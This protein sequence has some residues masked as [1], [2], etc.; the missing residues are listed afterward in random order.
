[1]CWILRS[2][3]REPFE[4]TQ[5]AAPPRPQSDVVGCT[6]RGAAGISGGGHS[7]A[8]QSVP[9]RSRDHG[10]VAQVE[11]ERGILLLLHPLLAH[12]RLMERKE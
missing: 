6:L 9:T 1:M 3:R 10:A 8:K 4:V 2:A 11:G 5:G 12:F 7:S